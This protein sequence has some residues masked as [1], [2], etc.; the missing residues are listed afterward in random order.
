MHLST[1]IDRGLYNYKKATDSRKQYPLWICWLPKAPPAK[2][3]PAASP[4]IPTPITR[5]KSV[6]KEVK[7]ELRETLSAL[8]TLDT[9]S[10]SDHI[11]KTSLD[12]VL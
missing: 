2:P 1:V 10:D 7:K 9:H 3:R 4:E 12:S 6:R 11:A 5:K 8:P